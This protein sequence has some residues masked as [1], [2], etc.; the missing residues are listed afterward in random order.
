MPVPQPKELVGV[1]IFLDWWKGS[2]YGVAEELGQ[3][4]VAL[5]GDGLKLQNI[6]NRGVKV[7]PDGFPDTFTVDHWCCRFIAP[8]GEGNPVTHQ[9]IVSLMQRFNEAG[10][11]V[12]KTENL[13]NFSGNRG[14]SV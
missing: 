7:Y 10:L 13:Y 8:A 1:D 2:F 14:Y 9:Q 11:D 12:I 6:A 3:H 4:V 5:N